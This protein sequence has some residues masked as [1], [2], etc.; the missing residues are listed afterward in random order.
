MV[1]KTARWTTVVVV[2]GVLVGGCAS[3]DTMMGGDKMGGDKA[4]SGDK[5]TDDTM[6]EKK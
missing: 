2:A 4:M 1:S 5:M 3:R 6:M